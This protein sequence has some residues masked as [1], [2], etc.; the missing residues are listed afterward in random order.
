[1]NDLAQG[2][3]NRINLVVNTSKGLAK[4]D[5]WLCKYTRLDERAFS[6]KDHEMQI[7]I[8]NDTNARQCV[9]KCSQVGLS[10]LSSRKALGITAMTKGTHLLYVLPTRTFSTKFSSSRVNPIIASSPML[11]S[12]TSKTVNGSELKQIGSSYF[13]MGGTS[14][15]VTGAISVP[16]KYV[17]Q[18]E[19]DF[20]DQ[21]T[22]STYESRLKH[23][24]EDEHGR[25]GTIIKFSTPTVP[26][27]GINKEFAASDQKH[28]NVICEHC[29]H[30]FAPD[31]F[32][33]IK[34]PD[35]NS[36]I[37]SLTPEDIKRGEYNIMGAYMECPKCKGNLN[38]SLKMPERRHWVAKYP[39]RI[40]SGYQIHPWDV[41]EVNSIP[42]I[43]MQ[44]AGYESIS[45]YYNFTVGIP[46]VD[47]ENSFNEER[48]RSE[49]P[50]EFIRE[51]LDGG[52][53]IGV[54]V[55]KTSHIAVGRVFND[56]REEVN[57]LERYT[58]RG[59]NETLSK[60]IVTLARRYHAKCVVIDAAPDFTTALETIKELP[61]G[62]VYACEYTRNRGK[63]L[64][65]VNIP[66]KP[67][68]ETDYVV[69]A[70]RTGTL[71]DLLKAHNNG[72]IFYFDEHINEHTKKEIR[73]L[74]EHYNNTKK[75]KVT[76]SDGNTEEKFVNTG[77]DHYTH[78][79]NY[80][81]I[82]AKIAG[83]VS[84]VNVPYRPSVKKFKHKTSHRPHTNLI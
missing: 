31:Y 53:V 1:M 56:G 48:I 24:P 40:I 83:T 43:L 69:K 8:V 3:L 68:L 44:L 41:P 75:I 71:Q 55:G 74:T 72:R 84:T 79:M 46:W 36:P 52:F 76:D 82:A 23:A 58:V 10:E 80:M 7:E 5:E 49:T 6:F 34:I 33:H 63:S 81:R 37:I 20:C 51:S 14:G 54:D 18:D 45:D 57:Y 59:D 67:E 17:I 60:H 39:E 47:N 26:D 4:M 32:K 35:F 38:N 30:D 22:L 13:H 42:S 50:A 29:E 19:V 61:L 78:A 66:D 62:T 9:Q 2:I 77:D 15:S 25:K 65:S 21:K 70:Y 73:E 27:F 64:E 28:Y 16:A 12:M 11:R